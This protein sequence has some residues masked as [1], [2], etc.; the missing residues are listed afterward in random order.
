MTVEERIAQLEERLAEVSLE[1]QRA[2]AAVEIQSV[3]GRYEFYYMAQRQDLMSDL[4]SKRPDASMDIMGGAKLVNQPLWPD[5]IDPEAPGETQPTGTFRV[6]ALSTPVVEVAADCMTAR[7]TWISPGFDT[8]VRDGKA[9]CSWCWI[10]YGCDFVREDGA[11]K[12]WHLTSYGIIHTDYYQSWGD[13]EP[14]PLIRKLGYAPGSI[15]T[16]SNF[17]PVERVDWTYAKDRVPELEPV[18][19][20]PYDTWDSLKSNGY[21][22]WTQEHIRLKAQREAQNC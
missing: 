19:P 18:P 7:A 1:A 15:E 10:K 21:R 4:W 6:H 2:K 3:M 9:N 17:I 8:D 5:E 22:T 16:K 11:W 20:L 13:K 12:L 14:T